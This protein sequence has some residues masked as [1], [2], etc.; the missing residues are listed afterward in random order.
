[1]SKNSLLLTFSSLLLAASLCCAQTE[2]KV[3][4]PE[5]TERTPPAAS[6]PSEGPFSTVGIGIQLSLLGP[7]VE[8]ATPLANNSNL[9][10]AFNTF[11]YTRTFSQDGVNYSGQLTFRSAQVSYDWFPFAG[12]FHLSPGVMVY[13]GNQVKANAAVPGGQTFTLNG[14]T[15]SSDASDPISGNGSLTF[16]KVA[17]EVLVGWG[18][19][20][21]RNGKH[22]S[23]PFEVGAVYQGTPKFGLN[24]TGT[25]CDS[26]GLICDNVSSDPTFQNNLQA[27]R[28]KYQKDV[29]P[30]RFYPVISVGF[31]YRF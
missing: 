22:I 13:N 10:V 23:I 7:G 21:P 27:Q 11:S 9:R 18:N 6:G 30:F 8:V 15:Y 28:A 4:A 5:P 17:P 31:G 29:S 20:V 1:M 3:P 24:L 12:S 26:T 14:T 2:M 19:L 25:A 16:N